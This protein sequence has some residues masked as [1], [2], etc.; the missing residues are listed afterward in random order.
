M[1]ASI[2]F[3]FLSSDFLDINDC[4]LKE[5]GATHRE[6]PNVKATNETGFTAIPGGYFDD[7]DGE[8]WGIGDFDG[9]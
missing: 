5:T 1:K 6:S 8:F 3:V 2:T 4:S 9:W 7:I